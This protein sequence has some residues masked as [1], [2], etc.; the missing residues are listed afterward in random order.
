MVC[1]CLGN[2]LSFGKCYSI[3]TENNY[4]IKSY[5]KSSRYIHLF[6]YPKE[7][8]IITSVFTNKGSE[9]WWNCDLLK[10]TQQGWVG[11]GF[12]PRKLS[13]QSGESTCNLPREMQYIDY[14]AYLTCN[15]PI[16]YSFHCLSY[17][18]PCT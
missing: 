16:L 8:P 13:P 4:C 6:K 3:G 18:S 9:A 2:T 15:F 5:S 17:L 14:A 12:K 10:F 1:Q 11:L 7:C